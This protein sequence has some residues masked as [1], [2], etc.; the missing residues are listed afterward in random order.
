MNSKWQITLSVVVI[1]MALTA[2]SSPST[3]GDNSSKPVIGTA[4]P[5]EIT[6]SLPEQLSIDPGWT[7]R[8]EAAV[9]PDYIPEDIPVLEGKIRK[10]MVA[11]E[12]H[13]RIFYEGLSK[14]Q[15]DQYLRLLEQKGFHLEYQVYIQ[16]GFPDNSEERMKKG[17]Y[18]AVDITKG[19]YHMNLGYGEGNISYDIYTSGFAMP[20]PTPAGLD[21]PADLV[22]VVPKPE[23]CIIEM[24]APDGKGGYQ[25]T[26]RPADQKVGSDY[27]GVLQTTGFLPKPSSSIVSASGVYG[28]DDL[29]IIVNQPSTALVLISIMRI[30]L[31][32]T[33]WPAEL[34]AIVPQPENCLIQNVLKLEGLNFMISCQG[35]SD[36][37]VAEYLELLKAE[38]FVETGRI[39]AGSG[40]PVSVSFEG[41]SLEVQLLIGTQDPQ[42]NLTIKVAEMP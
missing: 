34:M 22:N 13:I 41:K 8:G 31:S 25:I 16:E 19:D 33:S 35:E 5:A 9:W 14:D 7:S 1:M 11:P 24:A 27:L 20:I 15:I 3:N 39:T 40:E 4:L 21:W 29:E 2:C 26:C 30:D 23:R 17:D 36:Q 37:V 6:E 10:V 32:K 42:R 18:D 28:K 12:S 38:G